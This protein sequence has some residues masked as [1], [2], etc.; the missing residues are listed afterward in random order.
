MMKTTRRIVMAALFA[1]LVCVATMIIKIPSPM[2][3]YL[4]I[5][6]CIV[7]T[8]GWMLSPAYGFF[9]AGIGSALADVFSGYIVYTPATFIIK[10]VMALMA[11]GGYRLLHRKTGKT[12][13]EMVSGIVA[14][15]WMVM[16]YFLFEGILYGFAPSLI[17]IPANAVQGGVGLILGIVLVKVLRKSKISFH[18]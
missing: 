11:W 10:G 9:A 14:E 1:S 3:G 6:D 8:A 12:V 2:K 15:L 13:A 18:E 16:G 7:L 17:N 5:G 4:N